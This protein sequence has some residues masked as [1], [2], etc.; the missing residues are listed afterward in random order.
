MTGTDSRT[1]DSPAVS[2]QTNCG[3]RAAVEGGYAEEPSKT[4]SMRRV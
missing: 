3:P 2:P 1:R 4:L